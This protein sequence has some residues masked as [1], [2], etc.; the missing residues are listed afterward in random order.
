MPNQITVTAKSGPAI[1]STAQVIP[2]VTSV[3]FD[4]NRRVL[5]VAV[6]DPQGNREFDLTGVTTATITIA[7]SG[8][9]L[10]IS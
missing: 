9:T 4:I 7:A 3:N 1:Q 2:N 6:S 5:F 8:Y 10:A